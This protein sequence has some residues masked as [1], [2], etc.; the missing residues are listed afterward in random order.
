[1]HFICYM[2]PKT[3]LILLPTMH[4]TIPR[5]ANTTDNNNFSTPTVCNS[6]PTTT[7]F[8]VY[9]QTL[10]GLREISIRTLVSDTI[11][12]EPYRKALVTKLFFCQILPLSDNLCVFFSDLMT[13]T[14]SYFGI[15]TGSTERAAKSTT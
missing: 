13:T 11:S 1:M 12:A 15:N 2:A 5:N 3:V 10:F 14:V 6:G 8:S 9:Q 4:S 7:I